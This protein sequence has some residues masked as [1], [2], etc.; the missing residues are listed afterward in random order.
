MFTWDAVI[1][2]NTRSY[3][4]NTNFQCYIYAWHTFLIIANNQHPRRKPW[5]YKKETLLPLPSLKGLYCSTDWPLW[6]HP[7]YRWGKAL[8]MWQWWMKLA[9]VRG[10]FTDASRRWVSAWWC[11]GWSD[12]WTYHNVNEHG[13]GVDSAQATHRP[14]TCTVPGK[15]CT[16]PISC[17][18]WSEPWHGSMWCQLHWCEHHCMPLIKANIFS[19]ISRQRDVQ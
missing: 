8:S 16:A 1:N 18:H 10:S 9:V 15:I 5:E 17:K 19:D 7:L 14:Q 13:E 6:E 2:E 12:H 3:Q 4:V 11:T